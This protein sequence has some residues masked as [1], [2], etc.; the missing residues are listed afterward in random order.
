MS[1]EFEEFTIETKSRV[2]NMKDKEKK[3]ENENGEKSY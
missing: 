2:R 3:R 1:E